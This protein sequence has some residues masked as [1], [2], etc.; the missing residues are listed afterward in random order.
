MVSRYKISNVVS[1]WMRSFQGSS[2]SRTFPVS[3]L[4]FIR[5]GKTNDRADYKESGKRKGK[6]SETMSLNE[7]ILNLKYPVD[8]G[9]K[10]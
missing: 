5:L 9:R 6:A 2:E 4:L 7:G 1:D 3:G 10:C 8:V